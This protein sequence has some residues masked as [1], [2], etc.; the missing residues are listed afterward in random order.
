MPTRTATLR[1][2]PNGHTFTKS[3][4]CLT[5]PTCEATHKPNNGFLAQVSAPARRALE[6]EKLTSLQALAQYSEANLLA[7]HGIG[8]STIPKLKKA[9]QDAGLSLAKSAT[10]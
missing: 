6:R 7:L 8:P 2:C 10:R 3:S 5:C 1:T 4:D 9:L